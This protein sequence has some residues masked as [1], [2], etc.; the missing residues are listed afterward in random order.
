[1]RTVLESRR[2]HVVLVQEDTT[3]VSKEFSNPNCLENELCYLALMDGTRCPKLLRSWTGGLD[4]AYLEGPTLLDVFVSLEDENRSPS[5]LISQ[6]L[7]SLAIFYDKTAAHFGVPHHIG[8]IN[9]RNFICHNG[10]IYLIDFEL[11]KEGPLEEDMGRIMAFALMYHPVETPW[12]H[13]FVAE[14]LAQCTP[15]FALSPEDVLHYYHDELAEIHRR[16]G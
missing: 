14:F 2:N 6:L 5:N 15:R 4:L 10:A 9:F 16:R 12:K 3:Y 11:C 8:D 1:M 13:Q 7:D